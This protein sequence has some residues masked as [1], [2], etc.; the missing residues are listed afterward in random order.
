MSALNQRKV[1]LQN[2]KFKHTLS[3]KT[4]DLKIL[5]PQD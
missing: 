4:E 5:Q 1:Q 3:V 2:T